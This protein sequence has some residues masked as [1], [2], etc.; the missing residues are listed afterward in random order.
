MVDKPKQSADLKIGWDA[1]FSR[2]GHSPR[3]SATDVSRGS[4]W[5]IPEKQAAGVAASNQLPVTDIKSGWDAAMATAIAASTM[6]IR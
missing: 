4:A 5:P 1:A 6:W 3:M 2:I